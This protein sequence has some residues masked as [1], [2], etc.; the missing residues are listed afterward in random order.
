MLV[1]Q[2]DLVT[3]DCKMAIK[4]LAEESLNDRIH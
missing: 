3:T 1:C 4:E 2:N